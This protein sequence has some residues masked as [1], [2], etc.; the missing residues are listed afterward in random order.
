MKGS[1]SSFNRDVLYLRKTSAL[2]FLFLA[3]SACAPAPITVSVKPDS[4]LTRTR[5]LKVF[6]DHGDP[7]GVKEKLEL[8]LVAKG[9][10]LVTTPEEKADYVLRFQYVFLTGFRSFSAIVVNTINNE[11]V[12][13][14]K[15]E[16]YRI[17]GGLLEEFVAKMADQIR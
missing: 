12:A 17:D 4:G 14:G 3:L 11:V 9:F 5:N 16:G 8:L 7:V 15:F 10:R 2:C 13:I 6:A 1:G